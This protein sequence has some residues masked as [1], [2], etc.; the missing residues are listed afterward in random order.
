MFVSMAQ[1]GELDAGFF[2]LA[3]GGQDVASV[4]LTPM[5]TKG[6]S[7]C[8]QLTRATVVLG[9]GAELRLVVK[10]PPEDAQ[11][12]SALSAMGM[13]SRERLVY[14]EVL[15][16]GR[17]AGVGPL[18]LGTAGDT[19]LLQDLA[20]GGFR[21]APAGLLDAQHAAAALRALARLHAASLAVEAGLPGSLGRYSEVLFTEASREY[22]Q[23]FV[24]PNWRAVVDVVATWD[25]YQKFAD[26]LRAMEPAVIDRAIEIVKPKDDELNVL[27]HGDFWKNNILFRYDPSSGDVID[28]R[29]VDYQLSRFSSPSLD[30]NYF[31]H[32][33]VENTVRRGHMPALVAEYVDTLNKQL[34]TYEV[35]R[36]V[37]VEEVERQMGDRLE[38][39]LLAA[40]TDLRAAM[41][42]PADTVELSQLASSGDSLTSLYHCESF[43]DVFSLML[44]E[45]EQKGLL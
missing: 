2:S 42:A 29:V 17:A 12:A 20:V 4:S 45:F 35:Q 34:E 5:D 25:G 10:R 38:F 16:C 9:D 6:S 8:G 24:Q 14:Q 37:T 43:K 30:L 44:L 11:V 32:T 3:L 15:S 33:S 7:F 19:L 13:F 22:V 28:A 39:A 21:A 18:L 27:T 23:H 31:F 26:K 41:S 1:E 36:R 40:C